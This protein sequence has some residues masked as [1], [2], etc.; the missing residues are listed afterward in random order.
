MKFKHLYKETVV[1]NMEFWNRTKK[2]KFKYLNYIKKWLL[3]IQNF[4]IGRKKL[5]FKH[6][7]IKEAAIINTEFWNRT[8]KMK[9]KHLNYI[10]KRLKIVGN[11]Y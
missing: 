1:I 3:S 8:K 2:M 6:L 7:I 5:K 11:C 9:F 4:G 10:K